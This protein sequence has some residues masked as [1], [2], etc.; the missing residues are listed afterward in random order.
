[1]IINPK[2]IIV[3]KENLGFGGWVEEIFLVK[4]SATA[5]DIVN[6]NRPTYHGQPE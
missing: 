2:I 5:A 6:I 4:R 1:L 3:Y